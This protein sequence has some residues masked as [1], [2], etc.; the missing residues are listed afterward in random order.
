VFL[1]FFLKKKKRKKE[2]KRKEKK[3]KKKKKVNKLAD[4]A[5]SSSPSERTRGLSFCQPIWAHFYTHN[6][7]QYHPSKKKKRQ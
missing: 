7:R 6:K 1:F 4:I 5:L 3:K 2:K